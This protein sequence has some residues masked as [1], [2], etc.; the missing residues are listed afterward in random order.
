MEGGQEILFD[1]KANVKNITAHVSREKPSESSTTSERSALSLNS[2]LRMRT[3][4]FDLACSLM[5]F[6][7]CLSSLIAFLAHESLR[8]AQKKT[9]YKLMPIMAII[10]TKR[11]ESER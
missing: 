2:F 1:D 7:S 5:S 3:F 4:N 10:I 8:L 6:A 9:P 11:V